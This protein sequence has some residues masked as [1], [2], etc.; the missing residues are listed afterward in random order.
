MVPA[1][2]ATKTRPLPSP[3]WVIVVGVPPIPKIGSRT[4]AGAWAAAGA[5]DSHARNTATPTPTHPETRMQALPSHV[6]RADVVTDGSLAL[7]YRVSAGRVEVTG[8]GRG[9]QRLFCR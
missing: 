2:V 6:P 7:H 8:A 4:T 5:T 9:F 1:W 3:A